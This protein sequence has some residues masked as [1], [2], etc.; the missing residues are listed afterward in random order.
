MSKLTLTVWGRLHVWY[1]IATTLIW[2][3]FFPAPI[4]PAPVSIKKNVRTQAPDRLY[5]IPKKPMPQHRKRLDK[6]KP[7][8]TDY[9]F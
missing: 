4:A 3:K 7:K 1:V 8:K 9:E 6:K 5:A 2:S